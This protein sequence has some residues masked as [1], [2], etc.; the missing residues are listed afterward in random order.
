[1]W[2]RFVVRTGVSVV[3]FVWAERGVV[4]S[5]HG[6]WVPGGGFVVC[7]AERVECCLQHARAVVVRCSLCGEDVGV[8]FVRVIGVSSFVCEGGVWCRFVVRTGVSSFVLCERVECC[9]QQA[10]AVGSGRGFRR[11]Y[12]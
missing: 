10:W 1:M 9:L 11:L 7:I 12:C 6:R 2:C 8:T 4:Y 3:R 5:R